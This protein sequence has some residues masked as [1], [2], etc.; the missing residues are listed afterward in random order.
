MN[1]NLKKEKVCFKNRV[2]LTM[3]NL[4][5]RYAEFIMS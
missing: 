5:C 4:S 1:N 2:K 3:H